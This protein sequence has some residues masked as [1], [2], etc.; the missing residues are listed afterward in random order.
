MYATELVATGGVAAMRLLKVLSCTTLAVVVI[1][2][3]SVAAETGYMPSLGDIMAGI[4]LR[5]AKLWYAAR[6]KNWSLADY[7]ARELNAALEQATR[8][9]PSVPG[10][11]MTDTEQ[12]MVL[13]REAIKAQ[14]DVKFSQ[15]FRQMTN[16]CN[17]CHEAT[18]RAFIVIRMPVFPLRI[19][20]R[21]LRLA[22]RCP[23]LGNNCP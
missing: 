5:H 21:C 13:L 18:G 23:P 17:G 7:E 1:S 10:S 6:V 22:Q 16:A 11:D 8:L 14:D 19:A 2:K 9:F 3:I 20:I 4:Q 12:R 15:A